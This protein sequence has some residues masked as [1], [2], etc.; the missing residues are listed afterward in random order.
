VSV[1]VVLL[2]RLPEVPVTVT[3]NL[4]IAAVPVEEKL[5]RVVLVA[6][7]LPK[8]GFTPLGKPDATN[9]T[10]PL[11]PFR[12]MI[13]I[14]VEPPAPWTKVKLVGDA[15]SVKLGCSTEPDQL[16]T[17]FAALTLPMPVAKS[18]PVV[19]PYAGAKEVSEVESTPTE[20]PSR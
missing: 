14:V 20:A 17:K 2:L 6:G 8:V 18:H 3:V 11:N 9:F 4:P 12:E 16:F 19:V 7:F 15:E 1:I 10:L 5:N 13:V